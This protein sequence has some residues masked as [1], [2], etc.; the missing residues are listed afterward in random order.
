MNQVKLN[1]QGEAR[2]VPDCQVPGFPEC[3]D[4]CPL[5]LGS[6]DPGFPAEEVSK[7][8]VKRLMMT[9]VKLVGLT[10]CA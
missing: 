8:K 7:V 2:W 6:Q 3:Q 1:D 9:G 5:V 10:M 4:D